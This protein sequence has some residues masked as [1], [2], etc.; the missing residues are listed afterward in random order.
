MRRTAIQACDTQLRNC[1]RGWSILALA[2]II[3][4][5]VCGVGLS[6]F[7]CCARS[8]EE[9][10]HMAQPVATAITLAPM[11]GG[12]Y[13]VSVSSQRRRG[14][15]GG[16]AA[17]NPPWPDTPGVHVHEPTLCRQTVRPSTRLTVLIHCGAPLLRLQT[18][19]A[20]PQQPYYYGSP[21]APGNM[22]M[23]MPATGYPSA[24]PY[25]AYPPPAPG[26]APGAYPP[27]PGAYP[28][29]SGGYPPAPA[30]AGQYA[31]Q[32]PATQRAAPSPYQEQQQR[33]TTPPAQPAVAP[34]ADAASGSTPLPAAGPPPIQPKH[35]LI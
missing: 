4:V 28:P 13:A 22:A 18:Y 27:A 5:A 29:A 31:Q 1:G 34:V 7:C 3:C 19:Q 35:D 30:Q 20:G 12:A 8:P 14:E 16:D 17:R 9:L 6:Y 10:S 2:G 15:G 25:G 26:A 11:G 33:A 24:A 32:P 21:P 23:G